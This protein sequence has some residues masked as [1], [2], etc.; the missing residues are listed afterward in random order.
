MVRALE[1]L[2][3]D[4]GRLLPFTT[5]AHD[6]R[7][8]DV[9][10]YMPTT[11]NWEQGCVDGVLA[12]LG[13]PT[14]AVSDLQSGTFERSHSTAPFS[15]HCGFR[16]CRTDGAQTVRVHLPYQDVYTL[17]QELLQSRTGASNAELVEKVEPDEVVLWR[18]CGKVA[19]V[20]VPPN[21]LPRIGVFADH[22]AASNV[23]PETTSEGVASLSDSCA[24]CGCFSIH[25]KRESAVLT[26]HACAQHPFQTL[27][28]CA[29]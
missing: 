26:Q 19:E 11:R 25:P 24:F 9:G 14:C 21:L 5:G 18:A 16:P 7:L 29:T 15:T 28:L 10:T 8:R 4:I 27:K 3:G 12:V 13:C 20:G 22:A 2:P 17:R 23:H 1:K 6:S